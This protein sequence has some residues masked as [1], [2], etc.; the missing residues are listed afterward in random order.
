MCR[1]V[2]EVWNLLLHR[3]WTLT[4]FFDTFLIDSEGSGRN[5]DPGL[6]K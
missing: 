4:P 3:K 2:Q 5:L 6:G 1:E